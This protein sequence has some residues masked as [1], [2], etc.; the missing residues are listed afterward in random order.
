M[1]KLTIVG[2]VRADGLPLAQG[3]RYLNEENG[4]NISFYKQ[5]AEF[6]LTE[7]SRGNLPSSKMTIRV[8]HHCFKYPFYF[9]FPFIY[10]IIDFKKAIIYM[11]LCFHHASLI[12]HTSNFI[13]DERSWCAQTMDW[14]SWYSSS[15]VLKTTSLFN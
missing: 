2:R 15:F 13:G 5:Q 12:G 9:H 14:T 3:P 1:V 8:D 7:I 6:I 4:N 11:Q 10:H